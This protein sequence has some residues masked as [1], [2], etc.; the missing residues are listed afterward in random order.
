MFERLWAPLSA[1]LLACGPA[2]AALLAPPFQDHAV[3]QR[4]K[5][6]RLW[7]TALSSQTV[8]ATLAG[9]TASATADT[10]GAWRIEL[11]P[12]AAGGPYDLTV[13]SGRDSETLHDILVGDVY[14]CSGQ[15]NMELPVRAAS[16]TDTE[17]ANSANDTIRLFHLARAG[18]VTPVA[19]IDAGA[20]W[21]A[22]SPATV[23]DFSAACFFFARELQKTVNVPLGLI[24]SS[25]G[26]STIQ[27]WLS[28]SGTRAVG[29]Y[30]RTLAIL[31]EYQKTPDTARAKWRTLMDAWWVA[32]DRGHMASPMWSAPD[33][34]DSRWD[35]MKLDGWWES[36]GIAAFKNFD[37]IAWFRTTVELTPARAAQPAI[38]SLGPVDDI[39]DTW[40]NGIHLGGSEGW[41]QPRVYALPVG[42]L[43]PGTNVIAVGVLD[44]GGGGGL[45]GPVT[46]RTLKFS[47][48]ETLQLPERWR[49][50]IAG[51]LIETRA[52]PHAPWSDATGTTLLYNGMIAPIAPYALRGVLWYQGEAN[53]AEP[54][55]YTRL[56]GGLMADW[57]R[58]FDEPD[59]PFLIAQLPDFGDAAGAPAD[60]SWA[61]LREAQRKA[62][63]AARHAALAVTVDIG[64][65]Y[66]IHPTNKQELGRRL[67]LSAERLI[68]GATVVA[69][70]PMPASATRRGKQVVVAFSDTPLVVYGDRRPIGFQLCDAKRCDYAEAHVA[71]D[72]IVLDA[73]KGI[74]PARVRFCWADSP[75]C[76]L[77]NPAALPA[78]PFE[79]T[80]TSAAR[81]D[82]RA[83]P[84]P[85]KA[86]P[87]R[88]SP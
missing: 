57:R 77:Y 54:E 47:G 24:E 74:L 10:S 23:K 34:D 9:K 14:L 48:G 80:V 88:S 61:N 15:S 21:A 17:L 7:G 84:R 83:L 86:P 16:N 81:A 78:S 11:A 41:D 8:S 50:G 70:G 2:Q 79:I 39:D 72:S 65:R 1:A 45:W 69:S 87:T 56:L 71:K 30:E 85:A 68:Y 29:G 6:I 36:S 76:N 55:E 31:A 53:V 26:G 13:Q 66:D 19:T 38:L 33:F 67:A 35:T 40:V 64:D 44:T 62:V 4:D 5:P 20:K 25:W 3:L 58:A 43:K 52:A 32:H 59:L 82:R 37:G 12:L 63:A 22:A 73:P 42:T 51:P 60:S 18:S 27:A 46:V 28:D 49:Y 75:V